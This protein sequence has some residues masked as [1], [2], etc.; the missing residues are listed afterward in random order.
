MKRERWRT[1]SP[2]RVHSLIKTGINMQSIETKEEA[3][4]RVKVTK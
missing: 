1:D 4:G 3:E 2:S